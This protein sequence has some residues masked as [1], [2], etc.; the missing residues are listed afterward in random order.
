M[1]INDMF[2]RKYAAGED[3]AG[4]PVT[5]VINRIEAEQMRPNPA[6]PLVDKW[7]CYFHRAVKGVIL[8]RTL[9][10]QIAAIHGPDTT[11]WPGKKV[12]LYPEPM[13][14]AGIKRVAIRA[15]PAPNGESEPPAGLQDDDPDTV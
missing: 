9:A 12:Q 10:N 3:L 14:V 2:P 5:L 1:N 13:T 8:S 7:V 6:A 11:T 15:R 4:K